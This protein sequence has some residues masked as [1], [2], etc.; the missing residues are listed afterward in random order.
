MGAIYRDGAAS[1]KPIKNGLPGL[2]DRPSHPLKS[3]PENE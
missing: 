2:P 1:A 3:H